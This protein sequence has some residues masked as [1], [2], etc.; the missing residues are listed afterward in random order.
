MSEEILY[1]IRIIISLIII[2]YLLSRVDNY[3]GSKD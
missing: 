2:F 3:N 1:T